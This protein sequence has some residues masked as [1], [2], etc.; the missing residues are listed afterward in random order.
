MLFN[1]PANPAAGTGLYTWTV[2]AGEQW[3]IANIACHLTTS[4]AV[5]SRTLMLTIRPNVGGV[6]SQLGGKFLRMPLAP[7]AA[8]LSWEY[9]FTPGGDG[10]TGALYYQLFRIPIPYVWLP[11][12]ST[13]EIYVDL[14]QAADQLSFSAGGIHYFK[15][16]Y[17]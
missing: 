5:A 14:M 13:I 15:R 16:L 4:A 7:Q 1:R 8:S 6:L 11:E 2:P 10:P 9:Q 17:L 12:G 3:Q